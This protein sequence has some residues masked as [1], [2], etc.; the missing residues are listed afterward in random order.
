MPHQIDEGLLVECLPMPVIPVTNE[1]TILMGDLVLADVE[2]AGLY[3]ECRERH[4]GLIKAV[5]G[6]R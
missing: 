1:G 2:L 3:A 4:R 6:M 5:R